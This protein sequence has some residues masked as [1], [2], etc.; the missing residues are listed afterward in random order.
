ML[1]TIVWAA[2][3]REVA[4]LP[5]CLVD[6]LC[7]KELVSS[8]NRPAQSGTLPTEAAQIREDRRTCTESIECRI[9]R[10]PSWPNDFL[11]HDTPSLTRDWSIT[12]P[13]L[14]NICQP[15]FRRTH[16]YGPSRGAGISGIWQSN[17]ARHARL[18][19]T[20]VSSNVYSS[21]L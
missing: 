3:G 4:K 17:H 10:M 16:V 6:L 19:I 20:S 5:S 2:D 18:R 8:L 12:V 14:P 13:L 7:R 21:R 11:H 1:T 15:T 9:D